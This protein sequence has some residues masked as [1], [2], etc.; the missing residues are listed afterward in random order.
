ML[1]PIR[2][3]TLTF[4]DANVSVVRRRGRSPQMGMPIAFFEVVSDDHERAQ[5]FYAALFDWQVAV[6]PGMGGY[7]LVD[8]GSGEGAIGGGLGAA[9]GTRDN[10]GRIFVRVPALPG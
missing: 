3:L 2:Q 9:G 5:K 8:T 7:G 6:D 10:R 4:V 1:L